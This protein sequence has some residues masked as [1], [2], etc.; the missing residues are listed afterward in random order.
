[1]DVA[2]EY[3]GV[4]VRDPY[5]WLE[6]QDSD[7]TG[8]WVEA[9]NRRTERWL[10]GIDARPRIRSRLEE[11]WDFARY[12]VPRRRGDWYFFAKNE[13]LQ[14]QPVLYRRRGLGRDA[15]EVLDPNE[16]SEDGAVALTDY[17]VSEDATLM[18]YTLSEAGSDWQT[19]R[20][21]DLD[22]GEDLPD[23]LHWMK[24]TGMTWAPDGSG[25][26]YERYPEPGSIPDAPPS[27]HHKVYWHR[28]GAPQDDDLLV[29][30]RPDDPDLGFLAEVTDDGAYLILHT[31]RGTDTRNGLYLRRLHNG[32]G[33]FRRLLEDGEAK[34]RLAGS[35]GSLFIFHTDLDAS[36]GR[37]IQIDVERPDRAD[38]LELLPEA[39]DVLD[40]ARVVS[41]RLILGYLHHASHRVVVHDLDGELIEEIELPGL[42]SIAEMSG[43][44][45]DTEAFFNFQSQL[46]PPTILRYEVPTGEIETFIEPKVPFDRSP[47]L[48]TQLFATSDDGVRIPIFVTHRRDVVLD[49]SNPTLL[50]GYGGFDISLTPMFSPSR[51]AFWEHG[52]VIVDAN[53]RG[54]GEYG[55]DWHRAGMLG[56]KQR[57]FDDFAAVAEFLITEK[58]TSPAR[59]AI[60]GGSNG[61]LLVAASVLQRPEL[62][63]A[64]VAAVPVADMLR[65]HRFTAGRYWISEYGN[66]EEN[67]EHFEFLYAYSPVHNVRPDDRR[68]PILITT[69]ETDDRVVPM[70]GWKFAAALQAVASADQIV[71]LRT[72]RR[73]G[74]GL[75]K[76]TS[77]V[78]DEAA[79]VYSFLLDRLGALGQRAG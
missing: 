2:D 54:G 19:V 42:G 30:E 60:L 64:A 79:D 52:G 70:H 35:R 71:L 3:H 31:W 11:L 10:A 7:Q 5:R 6:D 4:E 12:S 23:V 51:I 61:G 9:Q 33:E 53:L 1:M 66:A 72:E 55:E 77:K 28:L 41:D 48:V 24:F 14:D 56:N 63:G 44:E 45:R 67:A 49:G 50:Y 39:D 8:A 17:S 20:V 38:W 78:I 25:F 32:G 46:H 40:F 75:G 21:R 62:F 27:T 13:G 29:Y 65:Y 15:E 68:P 22:A 59:L 58:W 36:R 16:L 73:A 74:H 43:R 18:A 34:Y 37:I 47:Y 76:P 26:Y 57:V 69:A